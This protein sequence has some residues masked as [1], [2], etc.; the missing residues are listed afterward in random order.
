MI[1][2]N[3]PIEFVFVNVIRYCGSYLSVIDRF[4]WGLLCWEA[5]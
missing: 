3:S 2:S 5:L 1:S 4:I